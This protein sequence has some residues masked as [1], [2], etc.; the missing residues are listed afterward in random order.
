MLKKF[1]VIF[2]LIN[3][4]FTIYANL[5][6]FTETFSNVQNIPNVNQEIS[7][8]IPEDEKLFWPT[9]GYYNITSKFGERLSPITKEISF[10]HGIDI[11]AKEGSIIYSASSGLVSFIGY[12]GANGYSIHINSGNLLFIYR[13]CV[14][15]LYNKYW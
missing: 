3:I 7:Y 10:H 11:G 5:I 15:K 9:P 6:N 1:L 4:L 2:I 14:S 12:N 13:S 8:F